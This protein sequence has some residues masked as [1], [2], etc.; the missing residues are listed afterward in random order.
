MSPLLSA[1]PDKQR[2]GQGGGKMKGGEGGERREGKGERGGGRREEG[3][4]KAMGRE[5]AMAPH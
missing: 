3:G 4:G 1:F 5:G 2:G